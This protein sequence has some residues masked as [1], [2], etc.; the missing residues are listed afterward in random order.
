[1]NK[2]TIKRTFFIG[3]LL[4]IPFAFKSYAGERGC[5]TNPNTNVGDCSKTTEG[6]YQCFYGIIVIDCVSSN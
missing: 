1:M 4:A 6:D 5:I 2:T 3:L